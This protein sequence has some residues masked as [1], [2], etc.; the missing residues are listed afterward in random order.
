MISN[1]DLN[2]DILEEEQKNFL[3]HKFSRK[4]DFKRVYYAWTSSNDNVYNLSKTIENLSKFLMI[5]E[6]KEG[7]I[8][9]CFIDRINKDKNFIFNILTEEFIYDNKLE[10]GIE[11]NLYKDN[12]KFLV[13]NHFFLANNFLYSK[14]NTFF[15]HKLKMEERKFTCRLIEI[16]KVQ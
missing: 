5:I 7:N 2:S 10:V 16:Y 12:S 11:D 13:K 1:N 6:T 8:F 14:Y 4:Y 9:G 3:L 15:S